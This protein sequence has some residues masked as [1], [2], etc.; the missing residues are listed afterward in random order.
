M[1]RAPARRA[2]GRGSRSPGSRARRGRGAA[3]E[4]VDVA[5]LALVGH[6]RRVGEHLLAVV[7][8]DT[9]KPTPRRPARSPARRVP[10]RSRPA[11]PA[12]RDTPRTPPSRRRSTCPRSRTRWALTTCGL[13]VAQRRP[14]RR[15]A[16][17][18]RS[19][20]RRSCRPSPRP[21]AAAAA[22][23]PPAAPSRCGRSPSPA[24]P[25]RPAPREHLGGGAQDLERGGCAG[26]RGAVYQPPAHPTPH[27]AVF[28]LLRGRAG[29]CPRSHRETADAP[30]TR[31]RTAPVGRSLLAS[32]VAMRVRRAGPATRPPPSATTRRPPPM[33]P[34]GA[35][36]GPPQGRVQGRRPRRGE[37][38]RPR[39][40]RRASTCKRAPQ[41]L[42]PA[43]RGTCAAASTT[44]TVRPAAGPTRATRSGPTGAGA[45]AGRRRRRRPDQRY[46]E[47]QR[48]GVD[49]GS[50]QALVERIYRQWEDLHNDL[51]GDVGRPGALRRP[52][53]R[54]AGEPRGHRGRARRDRPRRGPRGS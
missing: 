46:R 45:R 15:P 35:R 29:P 21:R 4:L 41:R 39:A 52:D 36:R 47:L 27:P 6:E 24:P 1:R 42:P 7:D 2:R 12:R 11:A 17:G 22:R 37:G 26:H 18:P 43:G 34:D 30:S 16:P 8:D 9:R 53:R 5:E 23:R 13:A 51:G 3:V 40:R 31:P 14:A 20:R 28:Q 54:A 10:P 19:P 25:A 38:P 50:T 48:E 32:L 49:A 44:S 33:T